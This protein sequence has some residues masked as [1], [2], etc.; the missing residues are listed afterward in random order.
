MSKRATCDVC[1]TARDASQRA[2]ACP[3]CLRIIRQKVGHQSFLKVQEDKD[4]LQ[5][6]AS[7]S[8]EVQRQNQ[9]KSKRGS[10]GDGARLTALELK[11]DKLLNHFG[12]V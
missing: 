8:L 10:R 9:G 11:V 4:L 1:H 2:A 7:A 5:E 6:V 3:T 12:L